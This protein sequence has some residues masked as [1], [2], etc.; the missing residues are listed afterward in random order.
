M[1]KMLGQ[2]WRKHVPTER[3]NFKVNQEQNTFGNKSHDLAYDPH[4]LYSHPS[5]ILPPM[6][7][8]KN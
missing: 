2:K 4:N 1:E 5:P 8:P 6:R 7:S 3:Q